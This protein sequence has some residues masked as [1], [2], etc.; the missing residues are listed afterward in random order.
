MRFASKLMLLALLALPLGSAVAATSTLTVTIT[1]TLSV[2]VDVQFVDAGSGGTL[3]KTWTIA[4]GTI[5]GTY[6]AVTA[7][8]KPQIK[9][10]GAF[11]VDVTAKVTDPPNWASGAAAGANIYMI[12][13]TPATTPL[14]YLTTAAQTY[15][16]I[17]AS[18]TTLAADTIT[19]N[20]PTTV[21]HV[22][23]GGNMVVTYVATATP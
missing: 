10:N 21:S 15:Q 7:S 23:P 16:S 4:A 1:V 20:L 12:A 22:T 13:T 9:N 18:G 8:V 14:A 11:H 6:D 5:G 17:A 19:L 3:A 2:T